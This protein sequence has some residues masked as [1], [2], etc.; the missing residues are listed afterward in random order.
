MNNENETNSNVQVTPTVETTPVVEQPPVAQPAPEVAVTP[1]DEVKTTDRTPQELLQQT[2]ANYV[3]TGSTPRHVDTSTLDKKKNPFSKI[4]SI[5]LLII[6]LGWSYIV[7]TDYTRVNDKKEP[8]YCNW[9]KEKKDYDNG[10]IESCTGLGYKVVHYNK[11]T[12][13]GE[14]ISVDE[15]IPIWVKTKTLDQI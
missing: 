2:G 5:I 10:S 12:E 1:T 6:V 9:Q 4:F 15:F 14:K 8:K 13:A 11:E 3:E 7:Y